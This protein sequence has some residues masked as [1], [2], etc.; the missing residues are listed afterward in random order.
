MLITA[1]QQQ[2]KTL[3]F[4]KGREWKSFLRL[5]L[6]LLF[7]SS[8]FLAESFPSFRRTRREEIKCIVADIPAR[9]RWRCRGRKKFRLRSESLF[10]A[11][12]GCGWASPACLLTPDLLQLKLQEVNSDVVVDHVRMVSQGGSARRMITIIVVSS[13]H[14][15]Q[16][17]LM[18]LVSVQSSSNRLLMI[19]LLLLWLLF[20]HRHEQPRR[21]Y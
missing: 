21:D 2:K 17:R 16:I 8:S 20:K 11:I 5:T 9:G 19:I 10:N 14:I 15:E 7:F 1:K 6:V 18:R 13:R 4:H 3:P 12:K